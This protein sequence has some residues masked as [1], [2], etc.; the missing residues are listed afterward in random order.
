MY[1][2]TRPTDALTL[3]AEAGGFTL[4]GAKDAVYLHRLEN[5]EPVQRVLNMDL[6]LNDGAFENNPL[7]EPGDIIYVPPSVFAKADRFARHV[8]TWL[9]PVL[10]TQNAILNS[11]AINRGLGLSGGSNVIIGGQ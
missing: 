1:N 10:L 4:T 6:L 2:L 9:T 7:V 3:I 11:Q 5:G 8:S